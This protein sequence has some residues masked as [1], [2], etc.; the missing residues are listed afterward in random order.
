MDLM[1]CFGM[2]IGVGSTTFES[3]VFGIIHYCLWQGCVGGE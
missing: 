1:C 2:M 3:L